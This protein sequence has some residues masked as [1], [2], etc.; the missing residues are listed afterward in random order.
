VSAG[1]WKRV[2][3]CFEELRD[4]PPAE[5][6]EALARTDPVLAGEVRTLL[7]ADATPCALLDAPAPPFDAEDLSALDPGRCPARDLDGTRAGAYRIGAILGEGGTATVY[8]AV[9]L[10]GE[11][12]VALKL[13][14]P[15]LDH[16]A[17]LA[18]FRQERATLAGLDHPGIPR[19]LDAG[20]LPDGRPFLVTELVDGLPIDAHCAQ[21]RLPR[22]ARLE[23]FLSLC[24][25]VHHAHGHLVVHRDLKPSNVLV[26]AAGRVV[27][28]D[29]G[30]AKLLDRARDPRFTEVHGR[31]PLTPAF[32]SPEQVR[33][34]AVTTASDVY[35]LGV[36]L[37]H[38]VTGRAPYRSGADAAALERAVL[39]DPPLSASD[40]AREAGLPDVPRDLAAILATALAKDPEA[41][42]PSAEHLADDVRRFLAHRPLRGR[43][44]GPLRALAQ[45][46][47]RRPLAAATVAAVLALAAGDWIGVRRSLARVRASE[48]VAWRAHADAAVAARVLGDLLAELAAP[49][50]HGGAG[51]REER[52]DAALAGAGAMLADLDGMPE[53]ESRIRLA[54]GRVER[55][56]G[57][58]ERAREHL[59]RALALSR[60]T[61]G[62]TWRDTER[63][64]AEL[65]AL[66]EPGDPAA[67]LEHA[68]A[69]AALLAAHPDQ[70]TAAALTAA[71]ADVA[72]LRFAAAR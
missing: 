5:R 46:A 19:V 64:L 54:L 27:V 23:L 69:R 12:E 13:L 41:R 67:A 57:A 47:R 50:S 3:A 15:G 10:D 63:C 72:R 14:K 21:A 11:R 40:A 1:D 49:P 32:A 34:A 61:R 24:G 52:V 18:R 17:V 28:L 55:A 60:G 4:R 68:R 22:R 37:Y 26:T 51:A 35:S 16:R 8:R 30:I 56:R 36:V 44:A 65:V 6:E 62:L 33:G 38:L 7:A 45:L 20:Q 31:S 25:A 58:N 2:R 29:F 66:R 9:A 42:Y 43:R 70:V 71:E 39:R 53:A 59:E 48:T